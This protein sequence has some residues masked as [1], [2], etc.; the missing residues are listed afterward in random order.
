MRA[1][2][3]ITDHSMTAGIGYAIEAAVRQGWIDGEATVAEALDRL[4]AALDAEGQEVLLRVRDADFAVPRRF[5]VA[6]ALNRMRELRV[7]DA[8]A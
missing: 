1:V 5:E 3:Q 7:R 2:E 6:A 8:P 4:D